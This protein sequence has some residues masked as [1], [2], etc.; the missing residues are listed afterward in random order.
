MDV[1]WALVV[2]VTIVDIGNEGHPSLTVLALIFAGPPSA[3]LAPIGLVLGI[4]SLRAS[5][6]LTGK[7]RQ[8]V[9]RAGRISVVF[10]G[11]AVLAV[12]LTVLSPSM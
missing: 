5:R 7:K 6:P 2:L 9:I 8:T 3:V 4:A 10:L 1:L 11:A 12:A